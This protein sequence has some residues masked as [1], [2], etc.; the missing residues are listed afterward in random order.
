MGAQCRGVIHLP[1]EGVI[2]AG[3]PSRT[4]WGWVAIN[5]AIRAGDD[6]SFIMSDVLAT[7][8]A[9]SVGLLERCRR[10]RQP[11]QRGPPKNVTSAALIKLT[12]KGI[13]LKS[14]SRFGSR[15]GSRAERASSNPRK[16]PGAKPEPGRCNTR[17]HKESSD[18]RPP[19]IKIGAAYTGF[20]ASGP[21]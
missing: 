2:L 1:P 12:K 5:E 10:R 6:L 11:F 9:A 21:F 7:F 4:T 13:A 15:A 19:L 8:H 17:E 20:R 14:H 3:V 18:L 16:S